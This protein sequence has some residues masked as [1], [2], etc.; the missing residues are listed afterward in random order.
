MDTKTCTKC[1]EMKVLD[2]FY[3]S[4]RSKPNAECKVCAKAR[5]RAAALN[6]P[7]K[8]AA[9]QK[10]FHEVHPEMRAE[11]SKRCN[12]K[13]GVREKRQLV[14]NAWRRANPEM[15]RVAEARQRV[16]HPGRY[17]AKSAR[18]YIAHQDEVKVRSQQYA[19]AHPE[20]KRAQSAAY[21]VANKDKWAERDYNWQK[22]FPEKHAAKQA[23]RRAN[24]FDA[25][26]AWANEFFIEEA[27]HLAK[28]RT[29]VTGFKWHVD[30]I[31]PLKSKLVCGLHVETN[32]RVIPAVENI[33]KSNRYWPGMPV[34]THDPK[35]HLKG[36]NTNATL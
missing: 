13:P 30:H 8:T 19:K 20:E 1:G 27:Y 34:N 17:K 14:Q 32:L 9:N 22:L 2:E 23:K 16:A 4:P 25:S 7:D 5:S 15:R 35:T 31:V 12:S 10:Y 28:L 36:S 33:S 11:Y 26:P 6:N 18:Y 29:K 21:Y 3:L 24:K